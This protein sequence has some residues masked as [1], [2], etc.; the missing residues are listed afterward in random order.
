MTEINHVLTFP[1]KR[2]IKPYDDRINVMENIINLD[3]RLKRE[4]SRQGIY[5]NKCIITTDDRD[6]PIAICRVTTYGDLDWLKKEIDK[7]P[8][9]KKKPLIDDFEVTEEELTRAKKFRKM[10][11]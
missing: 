4:V 7:E 2:A 10:Y 11:D 3:N 5:N 8:F 9:V 6:N 1:V